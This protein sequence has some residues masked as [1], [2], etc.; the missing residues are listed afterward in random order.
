MP[1]CWKTERIAVPDNTANG[2]GSTA[3]YVTATTDYFFLLSEFEVFGSISYGNTNEKAG[4]WSPAVWTMR[5]IS[6]WGI[7]TIS[8]W[9]RS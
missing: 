7:C 8:P 5:G 1:A 3:S 2:G 6:L 9:R 4:P